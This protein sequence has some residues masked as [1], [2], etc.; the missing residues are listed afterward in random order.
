MKEMNDPKKTNSIAS[1]VFNDMKEFGKPV[2]KSLPPRVEMEKGNKI[3]IQTTALKIFNEM[4]RK[5]PLQFFKLVNDYGLDANSMA[6]ITIEFLENFRQISDGYDNF[7]EL[8][9]D[10]FSNDSKKTPLRNFM[11]YLFSTQLYAVFTTEVE[12]AGGKIPLIS[13]MISKQDFRHSLITIYNSPFANNDRKE[14]IWEVNPYDQT[15]ITE[16]KHVGVGKNEVPGFVALTLHNCAKYLKESRMY[17]LIRYRPFKNDCQVF[18]RHAQELMNERLA[19]LCPEANPEKVIMHYRHVPRDKKV[20]TRD[21]NTSN[22]DYQE[23]WKNNLNHERN[24]LESNETYLEKGYQA[25]FSGGSVSK[26]AAKDSFRYMKQDSKE[27]KKAV[28]SKLKSIK[29]PTF[30]KKKNKK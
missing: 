1:Q 4:K 10:K 19:K 8:L 17:S 29:K 15:D 6:D 3:I 30:K 21:I 5:D 20:N 11:D 28:G 23:S 22:S 9:M 25:V 16:K 18:S 24:L 7:S 13:G 12:V 14:E 26:K 27:M 2:D